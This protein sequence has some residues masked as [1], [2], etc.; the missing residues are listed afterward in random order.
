[1]NVPDKYTAGVS[2][3][4]RVKELVARRTSKKPLSQLFPKPT[5]KE[6]IKKGIVKQ[7]K[8]TTLFKKAFGDIKF[9]KPEFS[10]KF[11]IPLKTLDTVFDRGVAAWKS[12]GSRPGVPAAAWGTAR[13]YKFITIEKGKHPKIKSDPDNDLHSV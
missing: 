9:D 12:S 11:G 1:M 8:W 3:E 10:K 4:K 13:V 2:K 6:A 5:D 7:S